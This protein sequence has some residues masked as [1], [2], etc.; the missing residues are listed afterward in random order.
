M[1]VSLRKKSNSVTN[2]SVISSA[3]RRTK[4]IILVSL[5]DQVICQFG[6][7]ESDAAFRNGPARF[8]FKLQVTEVV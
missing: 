6:I 4:N 3:T 2:K 1:C 8:N 5:K 7:A